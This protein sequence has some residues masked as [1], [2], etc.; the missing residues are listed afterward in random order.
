MCLSALAHEGRLSLFRRLVQVGPEGIAAGD[1][2]EAAGANFTTVSAQLS[3]LSHAGLVTSERH[4]RSIRYAANYDG[5]RAVM[6]F[7]MEDCCQGRPEILT[8]LAEIATKA[9]CC[10]RT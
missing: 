9:A 8:P 5:I 3:V 1:L 4:G 10:G 6:A 2:A 7:L